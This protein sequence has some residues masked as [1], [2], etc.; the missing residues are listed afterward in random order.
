M[1]RDAVVVLEDRREHGAEEE[2]AR[3]PEGLVYV[4]RVGHVE[5]QQLDLAG[6]SHNESVH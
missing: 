1:E 6:G 2:G 5:V 3:A 4:P